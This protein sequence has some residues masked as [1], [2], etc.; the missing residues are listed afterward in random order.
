MSA[1]PV[2]TW[3][4]V[5]TIL[6]PPQE[7]LRFAAY[8]L[9]AGAHRLHIYLDAPSPEAEAR[10]SAHPK[11]RVTTCDA[12]YWKQR[13]GKPPVKHQVRQSMNATHAYAK[14]PGVDWLIHMDVDEFLLSDRPV[15]AILG[16]LP[17][18][19]L[20]SRI[21]PM[22]AL[23]G[24]EGHYKA[25]I[26]PGPARTRIVEDIYPT[27]GRYVK[28]GFLSHLAGK[29]FIR[30]GLSDLRLQIHNA[31]QNGEMLTGPEQQTGIDLAH[32]HAKDWEQWLAAYRYRLQKGSYR[33]ELGNPAQT[34]GM[35]LH[36]LFQTLEAEKGEAGLRA[37]YDEVCAGTPALRERLA[38]HGLHR[39]IDLQL[40]ACVAR[41]FPG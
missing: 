11:I 28:G 13:S 20:I 36:Q 24:A 1:G 16:A 25:F 9:E 30:T 6:A 35:T 4:L 15:A 8:H 38:R 33:A 17:A 27:F 3:G 10:L 5:A 7:I 14:G 39:R 19:Q 23:A 18:D 21:R 2:P 26:P 41:H 32:H 31:F 29:I 22:E 40:D 37:F 12:S 34:H